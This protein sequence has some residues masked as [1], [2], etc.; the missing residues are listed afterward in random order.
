MFSTKIEAACY[1]E[2]QGQCPEKGGIISSQ[3]IRENSVEREYLSLTLR[4]QQGGDQE[5]NSIPGR[6]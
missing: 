1:I 4:D 5:K 6:Q 3:G 2:A